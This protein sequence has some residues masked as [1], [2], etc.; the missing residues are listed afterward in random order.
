MDN[1]MDS[2]SPMPPL[3]PPFQRAGSMRRVFALGAVYTLIPGKL[4]CTVLESEEVQTW[5][6]SHAQAHTPEPPH[7]L[8]QQRW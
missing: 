3:Q 2:A 8:N 4:S 1:S 6:P 5:T 7:M